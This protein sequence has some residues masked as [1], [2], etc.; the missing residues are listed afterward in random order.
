MGRENAMF[1]TMVLA[2]DLSPV[3]DEIINCGAEFKVLGCRKVVLTHVITAKFLDSLEATWRREA[4]PKLARQ[5]GLLAAQGFEVAVEL[6]LGLPAYML[7]EVACRH[8]AGLIVLGSHGESLWREGVLGRVAGAALHHAKYP[9]LL[10][11]VTAPPGPG[12]GACRLNFTGLLR[13]IL[14][15]TDL[16]ETGIQALAYAER[17]AAHGAGRVTL[18]H[19][20]EA[21]GGEAYPP[22]FR[23][24]AE[25]VTQDFL[26]TWQGRL[27][28]AGIP[29][30]DTQI[31]P[32]HPIP[33]ILEAM[34]TLG[35]S[36][37]LMGTQGKGF[38]REIFLGSVAHNISRQANCPLL[39]IPPGGRR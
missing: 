18:L 1:D 36:L 34:G 28:A 39:L 30:V 8:G 10:L 27:E 37:V 33:V 25:T 11:N 7:N 21:P 12:A 20:L 13:H 26:T 23:E 5:Q 19:A 29:E 22:G 9:T 16:S 6:V 14:L 35:C 17:L 3:W 15:P 38:I 31:T 4:E 2:T 24:T 32:G